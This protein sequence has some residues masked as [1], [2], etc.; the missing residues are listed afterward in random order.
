MARARQF[1]AG[2]V[3]GR[4]GGWRRYTGRVSTLPLP[5]PRPPAHPPAAGE[6]VRLFLALWPD[7]GVRRALVRQRDAWS[8]AAGTR[9]MRPDTLHLTLHY[10]GHV[11]RSRLAEIRHGLKIPFA[12]FAFGLERTDLWR[13]GIAVLAT[14]AM[15][16][17]M[18]DLHAALGKRLADLGLPTD[19]ADFHPHV[20]LARRAGRLVPAVPPLPLRW[21]VRDYVLVESRPGQESPYTVLERYPATA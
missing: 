9:L 10:I 11:P 7:A 2:V 21:Q 4:F 17:G 5:P 19:S 15:A 1:P 12:P 16:P 13:H 3:P 6:E 18:A 20:T 14:D 8:A